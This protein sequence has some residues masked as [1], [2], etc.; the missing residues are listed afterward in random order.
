MQETGELE[1]YL[2][3]LGQSQCLSTLRQMEE[4]PPKTLKISYS[5]KLPLYDLK[6]NRVCIRWTSHS[7]KYNDGKGE[8]APYQE[9]DSRNNKINNLVKNEYFRRNILTSPWGQ[10]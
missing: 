10:G 3:E 9:R 7:T 2:M 8:L 6:Y 1:N 4:A 5:I